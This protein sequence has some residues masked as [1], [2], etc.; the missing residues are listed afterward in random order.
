MLKRKIDLFLKN[1]KESDRNP[2]IIYGARQI[3]KTTSIREFAKSYSSFVEINFIENP[4]YKEVFSSFNVDDIIKRLSYLNPN[5]K[6]IPND[7]LILFDEIQEY[8]DATTSLKFFKLDGGYD[9]ICTGSAL[10]VNTNNIS[11]VSVGYKE[12][13]IMHQLDFEEFLWANGYND[14]QINY[15]LESMLNFKPLDISIY[16]KLLDLYREFII[17]GGYPKIVNTFIKQ[18]NYSNILSMQKALYKDYLDDISKYLN[19]LDISK[20]QRVFISISSQLAKDNHK[21]QFSKLGH[22]S[23][24][25]EYYGVCDWLR[26]SGSALISNNC[27]LSIPLKGNEDIDN[28]RMYYSDTSLL[29]ASLDSEAQDDLR[30]NNNF[31]IYNG[32][33]YESII[34]SEL[35]KQDY[36]L[37][38][39]RNE[40][41]TIELDYLIRYKD[42]IVPIEVKKKKGRTVSLN[43]AILNNDNIK[44]GIKLADQNIGKEN[45]IIT[46]PYFLTFL[47]KRFLKE[48]KEK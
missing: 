26:L 40:S 8:M 11:S 37:Y 32:A 39:Y 46:F 35:I 31:M 41:S 45:N 28:F 6:F 42:S 18:N 13:Y 5:F 44:F 2:L 14:D 21:F 24:F 22:G 4:K 36:S 16:N 23:R 29:I 1:W 10:G 25:N 12:E 20:A 48:Y 43:T 3:G 9:V 33:L 38:Y 30:F 34:G 27:K 19:G 15:L 17:V 47:L 7:T